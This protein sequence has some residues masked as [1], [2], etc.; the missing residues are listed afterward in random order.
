MSLFFHFAN[1]KTIS[2]EDLPVGKFFVYQN[3]IYLKTRDFLKIVLDEKY[4]QEPYN[5][6]DRVEFEYDEDFEKGGYNAFNTFSEE[7]DYINK[8]EDIIPLNVEIDSTDSFDESMWGNQRFTLLKTGA[9]FL[10]Q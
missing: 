7:L 5:D 2:F 6:A 3:K 8:D 9:F 1:A 4:F 10:F